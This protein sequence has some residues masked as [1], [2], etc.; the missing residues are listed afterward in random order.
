MS[1][2]DFQKSLEFVLSEVS[3]PSDIIKWIDGYDY[4][5]AAV[6]FNEN[7]DIP[8]VNLYSPSL[9]LHQSTRE[10]MV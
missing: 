8:R 3:V 6:S 9:A 1:A 7:I 2:L 4:S 5:S 10:N